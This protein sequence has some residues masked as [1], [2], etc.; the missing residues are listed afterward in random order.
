MGNIKDKIRFVVRGSR[1]YKD[2]SNLTDQLL[3]NQSDEAV[4][5][6]NKIIEGQVEELVEELFLLIKDE[7]Q[8]V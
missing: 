3:K 2:F 4:E 5:S 8:K 1:L 6:A 7:E